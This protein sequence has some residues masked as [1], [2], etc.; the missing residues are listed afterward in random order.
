ML[1]TNLPVDQWEEDTLARFEDEVGRV[2]GLLR[3]CCEEVERLEGSDLLTYL[4]STISHKA[5]R[6]AVPD[7]PCY[8]DTYLSDTDLQRLRVGGSLLRWPKLG[9]HWLRC[10]GVKAYPHETQP[11]MLDTLAS[12]PLAYRSTLRYL[13]LDRSKAVSEMWKYRKAH[14]G[15]RKTL[16]GRA[17]E[18]ATGEEALLL[19]QAALDWEREVNQAQADVEHGLVNYDYTTQTVVVWDETFEGATAKAE[20]IEQ[21]LNN[22]DFVAKIETLNTMD[23]WVGTLPGN[24]YAN[25]RRPLLHS[26]NLAHLFPATAPWGGPTW[27]THLDGPPLMR[28]IGRGHTPFNLDIYDGDVGMTYIAG[29]IGS[30]KSTFLATMVM[31]WLKRPGA[32]VKIIDTGQSLRCATYAMGGEWYDVAAALQAQAGVG[33]RLDDPAMKPWG[34]PWLPGQASWQCFEMEDLL[35]TPAMVATVMGPLLQTLKERMTGAPTLFVFDEGHLYLKHDVLREGI[36]DYIRGLRKKN[37]AVIFATQSIA[38]AARSDA[39]ADYQRLCY[40]AHLAGELS[41]PGAGHGRDLS[42]V[43]AEQAAV[44]DHRVADP[45]A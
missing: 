8:L 10:V 18:T 42:G 36:D 38:D 28:T 13:P 4:H 2:Q 37:G 5:H 30:G 20:Q 40:D 14:Y 7:P 17:T 12:L 27:N 29:P 11:G 43:G 45:Q 6:V 9:P 26:H 31:Q 41:C 33:L 22:A 3:D 21:A 1:Y 34:S 32:E 19:N 16:G 23:A 15:Q 25:V 35:K 44:R 39:G 24:M